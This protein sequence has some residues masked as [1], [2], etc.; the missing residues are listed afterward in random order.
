MRRS[1]S[2]PRYVAFTLAGLAAAAAMTAPGA[3]AQ[4]PVSA[5]GGVFLL[6]PVGAR[7]AALG[8]AVITDAGSSEAVY[9]NPAGL[10]S[11][12]RSELAV[13]HYASFFGPGDA[14]VLALPSPSLGTLA[15]GAYVVD[16][17]DFPVTP[18]GSPGGDPP[19]PIGLAAVRN[20]ALSATYATDI[21]GGLAAGIGYKL[22]QF[23]LDCTG[24]CTDVP[25]VTGTTHSV[26]AGVRLRVA[27][28]GLVLAAALRNIG[29]KLQVNNQAQA[30]PLPTR[31]QLGA[32]WVVVRPPVGE[33]GFDIRVMADVRTAVGE[34][35]RD[36]VLLLG[37]DGGVEDAVRLRAGYAF[38]DSQARGPALGIGLRYASFAVD[39]ARL[40]FANDD[41]GEREPVHVSLRLFF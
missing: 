19:A 16:Y 33:D 28:T 15:L 24:T 37:V 12:S 38:L 35:R 39:L 20:V 10:A 23:R 2:S 1:R 22:V 7:A 34:D 18:P 6:L 27:G 4:S 3:A 36:P 41:L 9:W 11:L 25:V 26:D 13:H 8:Q 14:V 5:E 40:F 29:F 31:L 21:V 30:D 17:G 32:S